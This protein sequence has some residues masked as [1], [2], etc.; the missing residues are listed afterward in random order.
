MNLIYKA[1]YLCVCFCV[2]LVAADAEEQKQSRFLKEISLKQYPEAQPII[3]PPQMRWDFSGDRIYSYKLNQK[4]IMQMTSNILRQNT[5]ND[6]T[7]M[8]TS[9]SLQ[10]KSQQNGTARIVFED[11][12]ADMQDSK[13]ESTNGM[14]MQN[15]STS[16]IQGFNEDSTF[17]ENAL[18]GQ[19]GLG[20]LFTL[21]P[22]PIAQGETAE[23]P[24]KLP[25][26]AMGSVL[27]VQGTVALRLVRYVTIN[28]HTCVQLDSDIDISKID[29][30]PE[31][32]GKHEMFVRGKATSF[33]DVQERQF[34]KAS[35]AMVNYIMSE[36]PTPQ[37]QTS[38]ES[39]DI[40]ELASISMTTDILFEATAT[41]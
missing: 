25:F 14:K 16:V 6:E 39:A 2:I 11:L 20:F 27:E 33:F 3:P 41:P 37:V 34:V 35:V 24:V 7:T 12:K 19:I 13:A 32:K 9:G 23:I 29:V 21:P 5:P 30:P 38:D 28:N 1:F 26:S 36:S 17:K 22:R 8:N 10:I 31:V 18:S 4:V 40:P 15:T